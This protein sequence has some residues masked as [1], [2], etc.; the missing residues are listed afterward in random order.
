VIPGRD[1]MPGVSAYGHIAANGYWH[2]GGI[3]VC[4]KTPCARRAPTKTRRRPR[5]GSQS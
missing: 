5:D 1:Y 3:A 4:P 2:P